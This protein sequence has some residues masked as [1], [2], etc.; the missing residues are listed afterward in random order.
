MNT[1]AKLPRPY[2]ITVI[3]F[4]ALLVIAC[5][6]GLPAPLEDPPEEKVPY[7][8]VVGLW[9]NEKGYSIEFDDNGTFTAVGDSFGP[10]FGHDVPGGVFEGNWSLCPDYH[11][12]DEETKSV[13]EIL[14]EPGCGEVKEGEWI[15]LDAP[16]GSV[17]GWVDDL[18]FTG[19][20]EIRMYPYF[21][22]VGPDQDDFYTKA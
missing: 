19:D 2:L 15:A 6:W 22:D 12:F 5:G 8:D 11:G 13:E 20:E 9:E 17:E 4:C 7:G 21:I 16:E 1:P 18:I 3:A 14:S 10:G